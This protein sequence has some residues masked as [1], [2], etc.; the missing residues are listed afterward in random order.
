ML[1]QRVSRGTWEQMFYSWGAML[2]FP[3]DGIGK[4]AALGR[5]A[6]HQIR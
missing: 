4:R 3:A 5:R 6:P 1:A 2:G